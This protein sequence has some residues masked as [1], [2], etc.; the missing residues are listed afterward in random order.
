M[1][2]RN[3][4]F[5]IGMVTT[6]LRFHA[7]Y[8]LNKDKMELEKVATAMS[9]N[10][11]CN[12]FN[13]MDSVT[14][15]IEQLGWQ[16]LEHHRDNSQLSLLFKIM[17]HQMHIPINDILPQ[18]PI[19]AMRSFHEQNLLVPYAR[20]N[21]IIYSFFSYTPGYSVEQITRQN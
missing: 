8:G 9:C 14:T 5:Y 15:M 10:F 6:G 18:A 2:K 12:N 3:C 7:P 21:I 11:V 20:T 4:L 17:Q 13:P 19:T 1:S 16:K